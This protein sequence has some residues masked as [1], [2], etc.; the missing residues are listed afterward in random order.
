MNSTDGRGEQG[1]R[2]QPQGRGSECL[3]QA[4]SR[5]LAFQRALRYFCSL[6]SQDVHPSRDDGSK[7]SVCLSSALPYHWSPTPVQ[8]VLHKG[9]DRMGGGVDRTGL[10]VRSH[11][12]RP[13]CA[14]VG[15]EMKEEHS[16]AL[17][18][19]SVPCWDPLREKCLLTTAMGTNPPT[20]LHP[21]GAQASFI[22]F[23]ERSQEGRI[24]QREEED[25]LREIISLKMTAPSPFRN[26]LISLA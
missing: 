19:G 10:L 5:F 2:A 22:S 21:A 26:K 4:S 6:C 9:L 14:T 11:W 13:S 7:V 17:Y 8:A 16:C 24:C 1:F 12:V 18:S 25:D 15:R 20:K 23:P 3:R